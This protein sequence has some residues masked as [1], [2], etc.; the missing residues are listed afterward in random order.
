MLVLV[1]HDTDKKPLD[2]IHTMNK[3]NNLL[4]LLIV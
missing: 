4:G 3:N 1:S 2:Y